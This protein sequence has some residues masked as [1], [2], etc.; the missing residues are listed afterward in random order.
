MVIGL[1]FRWLR[2]WG[3]V[4]MLL[5]LLVLAPRPAVAAGVVGTGTPASCTE[6]ALDAALAG[7]G[8][9]TFDCGGV[10]TIVLS[11]QKTIT[12]TTTVDGGGLVT[13]SG[14]N[15]TP[16]FRVN[17]GGTLT[18]DQITM[19]NGYNANGDG[20]AIRNDGTLIVNDSSLL[21]N[22]AG[23]AW[24]GGAIVSYGPLTITHSTLAHN[25]AG[26][27][28]AVYPRFSSGQT[29]IIDSVLRDN[30]AMNTTTGWG[31]AILAW[32][33][34]AVTMR[35]SDIY[36]NTA[37]FGGGLYNTTDSSIVVDD[38]SV[39]RD[40]VATWGG[41]IFNGGTMT[42][43]NVT[44]NGNLAAKG[45]G[46]RSYKGTTTMI[47]VTFSGNSADGGGGM[48][49]LA[50]TASLTNVTFS[51][52]SA[53]EEGGGIWHYGGQSAE[54][55]VLKNTIIAGSPA[56][57]DCHV[58]PLSV[59]PIWSAGSNLS[60]DTSCNAY[61]TQPNDKPNVDPKLGPLADNGGETL[62]HMLGTGSPAID[63]GQCVAGVTTDQRGAARPVGPACDIGAVEYGA[64]LPWAYLPVVI[65]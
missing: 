60:S 58:D 44:L 62:T 14:G 64:F 30:H 6:A 17:A 38:N 2:L 15:A 12:A 63:S 18:L 35:D 21:N 3:L 1:S 31:G 10:K 22:Q 56:G 32:D 59:T 9:V 61:L 8:T 28:G 52:N 24:S 34:A 36:S 20:G 57:G 49:N 5:A 33:G 11:N 65:R 54:K 50:A 23:T 4:L 40:N 26:N 51:G 41:G 19:S 7:G 48:H 53:L 37:L 47:N 46:M 55:M 42:L 13:L 45:G 29:M 25:I 39:L 16:L 27:G 43:T